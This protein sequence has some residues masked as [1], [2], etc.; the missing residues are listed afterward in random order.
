MSLADVNY[1][2]DQN[3]C[4]EVAE[5]LLAIMEP[6]IRCHT[7]SG[8]EEEITEYILQFVTEKCH[9]WTAFSDQDGTSRIGNIFAVPKK[10]VDTS[11]RFSSTN[12]LPIL[13]AHMDTVNL[14]DRE[15]LSAYAF[16]DS[17]DGNGI[18][19]GYQ[20]FV[21]G[22]DDRA[23]I[24]LILHLMSTYSDPNFKVLFTVQEE[25]TWDPNLKV[26]GRNGG[27]GIQ[28]ALNTYR[29]FF[30][31]SLWTIMV[32]RAEDKSERVTRNS[33]RKA[34]SDIIYQYLD[35]NTCSLAFKERIEA[36]SKD[37]SMP[38]KSTGSGGRGDT[39][40]ICLSCGPSYSSVNLAAGGY[41]EHHPGD[42]LCIYQTVR[43]LRVIEECIRQQDE[44]YQASQVQ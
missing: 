9:G 21:L 26:D 23:G 24:A 14:N 30:D 43:T 11:N 20:N 1:L 12:R 4:Q 18:V 35:E 32:D 15:Q 19:G 40:N 27:G 22:F 10:Y 41:G 13:M 42:Y 6:L 31:T 8:K 28:Y 17:I 36:I 5:Q 16:P 38:M 33:I 25:K 44:L 2:M 39:C 3:E 7:P 37:L 34:P 29:E